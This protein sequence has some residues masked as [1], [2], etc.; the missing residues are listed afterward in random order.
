MRDIVSG[1]KP[2]KQKRKFSLAL[3]MPAD[4]FKDL[5]DIAVKEG[6]SAAELARKA[7]QEWVAEYKKLHSR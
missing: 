4:D 2:G 3:N 6:V 7:L 5:Y 1:P